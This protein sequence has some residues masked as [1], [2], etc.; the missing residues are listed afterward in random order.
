V[1]RTVA[2]LRTLKADAGVVAMT[3]LWRL[4]SGRRRA[5]S[6]D[7]GGQD[8]MGGAGGIDGTDDTPASG[9]GAA[10]ASGRRVA[11]TTH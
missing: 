6:N 1:G 10:G 2:R 9:S 11:P 8:G 4:S 7:P 5:A 3:L